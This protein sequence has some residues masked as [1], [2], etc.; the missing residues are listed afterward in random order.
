[1]ICKR[2]KIG[3][4]FF[5]VQNEVNRKQLEKL[6]K[7]RLAQCPERKVA[8]VTTEFRDGF[9]QTWMVMHGIEL[10]YMMYQGKYAP[11]FMC[12]RSSDN[13]GDDV[14]YFRTYKKCLRIWEASQEE[15]NKYI[16][17]ITVK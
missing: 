16:E 2:I 3:N 7:V 14:Y 8:Y 12:A 4:S 5:K 15:L 17:S 1:M 6:N 11:I 13:Y 9:M 10:S